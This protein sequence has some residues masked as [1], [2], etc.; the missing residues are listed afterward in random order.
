MV[1]LDKVYDELTA[2]HATAATIHSLAGERGAGA[3]ACIRGFGASLERP[4]WDDHTLE[5]SRKVNT[6]R[7]DDDLKNGA[8]MHFV[9][10]GLR[11]KAAD[12]DGVVSLMR[13]SDYTEPRQTVAR[14]FVDY[15][16][17]FSAAKSPDRSSYAAS[18]Y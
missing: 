10:E 13:L 7:E 17:P 16:T 4:P 6:A 15:Q 8:I 11:G 3:A 18:T 5:S 14:K 12:E 9:L 2:C 1:P